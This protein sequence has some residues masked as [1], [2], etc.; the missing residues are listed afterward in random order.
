MATKLYQERLFWK[1]QAA[2]RDGMDEG[3][4]PGKTGFLTALNLCSLQVT[5][6]KHWVVGF[7]PAKNFSVTLDLQKLSIGNISTAICP[8]HHLPQFREQVLGG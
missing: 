8:F 7:A 2:F 6:I 4:P 3:V 5:L 1:Y